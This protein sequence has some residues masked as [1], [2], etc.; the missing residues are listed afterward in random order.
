MPSE[1]R[2]TPRLHALPL[3]LALVVL[4]GWL[5]ANPGYFSHDELQ[6]GARADVG[7]LHELPW[8][9]WTDAG[10]FQ[11][12]PLTFNLWLLAS[13]A[14]FDWP[15]AMHLAWVLAGSSLALALAALL[16]RLGAS[17]G[18]ARAAALVFALGPYAAYVHGWVATLAD[19]LWLGA[20]LALAHALLSLHRRD[21]P[22]WAR[23]LVAFVLTAA[24]LLAK[25]AALAIPALLA[26]AAL[27]HRGGPLGLAAVAG[28]GLAALAYLGLRLDTLLAPG[29]ATTYVISPA[30][31]PR[32][33]ASYWLFPL[34]PSTLEAAGTW[35]APP[36]QLGL[37][38]G[39]V[40]AMAVAITRQAPR[41][42]LALVVGGSLALAPAL[43]LSFP[44]NQYGYGFWAWVVGCVALAWPAIGRGGR[45]LVLFLALVATWHG[46]NIQ[47]AMHRAGE[48]QAVFQPALAAA[49]AGHAGELRL[50]AP[51]QDDWLYRRLSHEVPS[52]RGQPIG[53]RVRWVAP[54]EEA[55]YAIRPDGGLQPLR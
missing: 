32:N 34:R 24:G 9:P 42:A 5:V 27:L 38:A 10:V 54:G 43:P 46:V 36:G 40:L 12:R 45:A 35:R 55:D 19:L 4:Q 6:W 7:A 22:P 26:L 52:W 50:R 1:P 3:L 16:A 51:A 41:L 14:L 44:A 11:W 17:P 28:S 18:T 8:M 31:A 39:L 30:A 29:D 47:R 15:R 33:W 53:D 37:A 20:G 48:R 49:L 25:E 13:H 23:W 21:A 2:P